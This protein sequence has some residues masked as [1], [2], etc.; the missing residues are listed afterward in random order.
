M[1]AGR[2][3]RACISLQSQRRSP[4]APGERAVAAVVIVEVLG[5][6]KSLDAA[7]AAALPAV[8]LAR[9][10]LATALSYGTLRWYPQLQVLL[11]LLLPKPL[12]ARDRDVYG[13]LLVGLY[14]LAHTGIPTYAAVSET[15]AA[16][17][18]LAKP[19]AATLVNGV[20][21]AYLRDR[22]RLLSAVRSQPEGA[23]AHPAWL[24]ERIRA[25]WPE[26]AA[27][28][29]HA[30]NEQAPMTL[31]VAAHRQDRVHYLEKLRAAG[32]EARALAE[33]PQAL[34]LV[35]PVD[36]QEL[37]GFRDGLV[38]VQDGASQLAAEL[39]A[40]E[41]GERVLDACAAP[42]GKTCH[43]LETQAGLGELWAVERD[44]VR[45]E[46]LKQNLRR[47]NLQAT[48]VQGDAAHPAGW[49]D[50]RT[51]DRILLDAPCSGTGVIRRHPDIKLL[52]RPSDIAASVRQQR[53]LLDAVWALLRRGGRLVYATC[54]ILPE[55]NVGQ[56]TEFLRT[57]P[58]AKEVPIVAE[59]G[60]AGPVGRQI[61]PG[62][63]DMDG[64]YYARL[65]KT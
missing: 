57:H 32:V 46:R 25:A 28:V 5:N 14:Q 9:R 8:P 11:A 48:V 13:L 56:V 16:V 30:N 23:T 63:D 1:A 40:A 33:A 31:R 38:S 19:W 27:A 52:R 65:E 54:S 20:L 44:A 12:R 50:G 62:D 17:T 6:G 58:D 21:R 4:E 39:L 51:F 36:V 53:D 41:G 60:R 55:E 61:L 35:R 26:A 10:P 37:P 47:L 64:F 42:G 15:V 2:A 43:I 59:W 7:L 18:Q 29:L 3:P 24:V 45:V 49:W 22:D 34:E